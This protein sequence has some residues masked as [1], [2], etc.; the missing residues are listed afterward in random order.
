MSSKIVRLNIQRFRGIESLDWKPREGLN[1]ILGGGDVGKT[2]ILDAIGLLLYPTNT[3]P[4]VDADYWRRK[5]ELEFEIEAVVSLPELTTI[6][7]QSKMNWMWEWDGENA[8]VPSI[9]D[10]HTEPREPVYRVRVRGTSDLELS[11]ETLQ[12]DDSVDSFSVAL[13]RAI[14]LVRLA[15]DDRNDRDLRLVQGSGLDRLLGDIGLRGRLGHEFAQEDVK[16]FLLQDK[17][18]A[19]SD[20]EVSFKARA[21]PTQLGLG[22]TGSSINALVGLTAK[23][24]EAALPLANW[25]AG[26]RRLAALAI[27]DALQGERPITVVDEIEKGLEP[28]RQRKL[29]HSLHV[30]GAQ[31]F[32]TTHSATVLNSALDASVWYLDSKG[33][34]ERLASNKIAQQ[35]EFDPITFLARLAV[36]CEGATEVGFVS[37]FLHKAIGDLLDHGVH[38]TDGGGHDRALELLE[39]LTEGGLSFAGI[40]DN[41]G[42]SPQR[43]ARI[44]NAIGDL[45]LQ[46]PNGCLEQQIIPLFEPTR[47]KELIEDPDETKTGMRLRSLAERL[48]IEEKKVGFDRISEAA[49]ENLFGLIIDAAVGA[50]PDG[51]DIGMKKHFQGWTSVWF[52]SEEGGRELG[53]KVL[54]LGAWPSLRPIVLPFLNAV[55]KTLFLPPI[56]D[57]P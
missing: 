3:Y 30:S 27:A 10:E 38:L 35:L 21:L 34:L 36:V 41:E 16:D 48:G 17:Q 22:I 56:E 52:K 4:L 57:F 53:N 25:G 55:R 18:T 54:S 40:V 29:I 46:W 49:G 14:G 13:R 12:P 39:A 20:L 19:L 23:K 32:I 31:V 37:V 1:I 24:D 6:S 11:Y 7:Q 47:L 51:I 50:L 8:V 44:K 42:R 45:F 2:T 28:Y 9:D 43:W 5:V 15:G 26:T 33:D